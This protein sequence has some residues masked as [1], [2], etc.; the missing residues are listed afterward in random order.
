MTN[1]IHLSTDALVQA[2]NDE[3]AVI[4]ASERSNLPK[5]L[6]I[7]EKLVALRPRIA[8]KHGEWKPA[9]AEHCPE[10]SYET[11]TVYIRLY[12]KQA[13]WRK[14]AVEKHADPTRLTIEG[15]LKL[16]RPETPDNANKG[17]KGKS[18]KSSKSEIPEPGNEPSRVSLPPDEQVQHL[19][20]DYGDMFEVLKLK[21]DQ[22]ELTELTKLLAAQVGMT[23]MPA[24]NSDALKKLLEIA[25]PAQ[26]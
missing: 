25:E 18:G 14:A 6:A 5:A 17:G 12:T 26:A 3:Y 19:E 13:E 22:D 15:V 4:L 20:L 16:L 11:A 7:G 1:V 10:I 21:Y 8:P 9:L 24:A 2:I 23:L